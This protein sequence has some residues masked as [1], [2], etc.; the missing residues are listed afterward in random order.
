M[1]EAYTNNESYPIEA[2]TGGL[3]HLPY[4]LSISVP[5]AVIK[6]FSTN[7]MK[8]LQPYMLLKLRNNF[9][10]VLICSY[11]SITGSDIYAIRA[12]GLIPVIPL[13]TINKDSQLPMCI[14]E[15]AINY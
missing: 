14:E 10:I 4:L 1:K 2:I 6:F 7:Y 11:G 3:N 8:A 15:Q 5:M 12:L 13:T 9:Y